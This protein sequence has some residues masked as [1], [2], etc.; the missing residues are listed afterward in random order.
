MKKK[1]LVVDDDKEIVDFLE[2]FL[3]RLK[4]HVIKAICAKEA[5]ER[6]HRH[7]PDCVFLDIQMP[8]K[9]GL[10]VLKELKVLSPL[11]KV[12][13]I[14][15]KDDKES[16]AKARKYGALDYITKPLDLSDLAQKVE[17]YLSSD[18]DCSSKP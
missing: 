12:I 2:H 7:H 17:K 6:Y 8:D 5:L 15:A 9:D 16:Q 10:S 3:G 4:L 11:L 14:T 18:I 1:V 13:M